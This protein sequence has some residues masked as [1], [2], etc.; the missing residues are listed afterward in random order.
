MCAKTE[1]D[2]QEAAVK[3]GTAV[4]NEIPTHENGPE[5]ESAV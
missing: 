2:R 3:A 5:Y 1:T 4:N